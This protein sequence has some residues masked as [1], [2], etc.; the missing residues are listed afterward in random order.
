[1]TD[2]SQIRGKLSLE[3]EASRVLCFHL[4]GAFV[5]IMLK[6]VE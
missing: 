1:M 5:E 3:Q 2:N 4:T 6:E